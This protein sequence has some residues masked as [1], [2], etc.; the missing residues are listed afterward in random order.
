MGDQ[1]QPLW[2]PLLPLGHVGYLDVGT[3]A[4]SRP[5]IA[6]QRNDP[7]DLRGDCRTL[8]RAPSSLTIL[9]TEEDMRSSLVE[10]WASWFSFL[11]FRRSGRRL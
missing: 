3:C 9:S 2:E 8:P 11:N 6:T 4:P 5:D 1:G 10:G 7:K